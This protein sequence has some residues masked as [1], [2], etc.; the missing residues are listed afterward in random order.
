MRIRCPSCESIHSV[1]FELMPGQHVECSCG[2]RF[3][4]GPETTLGG[5]V[6]AAA[7]ADTEMEEGVLVG[8]CRIERRIGKGAMGDVYLARHMTLD[9]PVAVKILR[10]R[11]ARQTEFKKRFYREAR[12]AARMDHPNVVRVLDCGEDDGALYLVMEYMGRGAVR[13]ML[14]RTG[15]PL[16]QEAVLAMGIAM[17]RALEAAWNHGIVHRDVKPDNIMVASDGIYKLADLGLARELLSGDS[18]LTVQFTGLGTPHYMAPEQAFD[19]GTCDIR[20]DL[21]SL[22]ATLYHAACG[23]PPFQGKTSADVLRQ[24]ARST[25]PPPTRVN[26]LVDKGFDEVLGRA[27]MKRPEH[28]YTN[29]S[30]MLDDLLALQKRIARGRRGLVAGL[31]PRTAALIAVVIAVFGIVAGVLVGQ[32]L[33]SAQS[34]NGASARNGGNGNGGATPSSIRENLKVLFTVG[35]IRRQSGQRTIFLEMR[36][37]SLPGNEPLS[38][39]VLEFQGAVYDLVPDEQ[40]GLRFSLPDLAVFP[41]DSSVNLRVYNQAGRRAE[42]EVE[43]PDEPAGVLRPLEPLLSLTR[44]EVARLRWQ[45]LRPGKDLPE[46]MDSMSVELGW[47][48]AKGQWRTELKIPCSPQN[49]HV[50]VGRAAFVPVLQALPRDSA[51]MARYTIQSLREQGAGLLVE[52]ILITEQRFAREHPLLRYPLLPEE[53]RKWVN[54][55]REPGLPAEDKQRFSGHLWNVSGPECVDDLLGMVIMDTGPVCYWGA[56]ILAE[57]AEREE[58]AAGLLERFPNPFDRRRVHLRLRQKSNLH[59]DSFPP[60]FGELLRDLDPERKSRELLDPEFDETI[61]RELDLLPENRPFDPNPPEEPAV[62]DPDEET[63]NEEQK[64]APPPSEKEN[65]QP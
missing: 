46:D 27:M 55:V 63:A 4:I 45:P 41:K 10:T 64:P 62:F 7:D 2:E 56:F 29:P 52:S 61:D 22:G 3:E 1:S 11:F 38:D 17:C 33:D 57:L 34:G 44:E 48:S 15:K 39:G 60:M 47:L 8:R 37:E 31:N 9:I 23:N 19:A 58:V 13:D 59:P 26:P 65:E 24:H 21:Y 20:A 5:T 35:G 28:R 42:Y 12:T 54:V 36:A 30:E 49:G 25:C 40:G 18:G 32:Q 43:L 50:D 6:A 14:D 51:L 53:T 16:P